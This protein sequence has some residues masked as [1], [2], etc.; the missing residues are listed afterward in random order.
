MALLNSLF[1]VMQESLGLSLWH[2]GL[3]SSSYHGAML[4]TMPWVAWILR[5]H[6]P[7][8]VLSS[9]LMIMVCGSAAMSCATGI[10]S[11]VGAR[12]VIGVAAAFSY[13]T[14]IQIASRWFS[15]SA[16]ARITGIIFA[17]GA[18]G[19]VLS[20][21]VISELLPVFTWRTILRLNSVL[22]LCIWSILMTSVEEAHS[23]D[24][25]AASPQGLRVQRSWHNAACILLPG[26]LNILL[27]V[28]GASWGNAFLQAHGNL[29]S[30]TSGRICALLYVGELLGAIFW[31]ELSS[32]IKKN[33]PAIVAG[34]ILA[35]GV[36]LSLYA[37]P[38]SHPVYFAL[39]FCGLGIAASSQFLIYP[40]IVAH[41]AEEHRAS[42]KSS[43]VAWLLVLA[44]LVPSL[45]SWLLS[46]PLAGSVIATD[47]IISVA[48]GCVLG[49]LVLTRLLRD[50]PAPAENANNVARSQ[51]VSA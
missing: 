25:V 50:L 2:R 16:L 5:R 49:A 51:P 19:G 8:A 37:R 38:F 29:S 44:S 13:V 32:R 14:C 31:G 43:C 42:L 35:F 36:L 40:L 15:A 17:M 41:N 10:S 33:K 18:L 7:V 21:W 9:T 3:L 39:S 11:A 23:S 1:S 24:E 30:V 26:C 12:A 27:V 45:I 47:R 28:F 34:I 4:L 6:P 20:Q 46:A 22:G 48:I